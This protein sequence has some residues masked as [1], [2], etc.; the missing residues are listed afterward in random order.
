MKRLIYLLPVAA[1]FAFSACSKPDDNASTGDAYITV[2]PSSIQDVPYTGDTYKV[3]IDANCKWTI[4][5]TDDEGNPVQWLKTDKLTGEGKATISILVEE[6]PGNVAR[7]GAVNITSDK[8]SASIDITQAAN[9]GGEDPGDDGPQENPGDEPIV[10]TFDFSGAPLAG[11]P[12]EAGTEAVSCV[13][14]LDGTDYTF[15]LTA[16]GQATNRFPYWKEGTGIVITKYRYIGLPAIE[17]YRLTK[18]VATN[19]KVAEEESKYGK[20]GVANQ[21]ENTA[22][23]PDDE[24]GHG[25]VKGGDPQVWSKLVDYTYELGGTTMNTVYY[26][27][28][29]QT[30]GTF[31]KAVTLTFEKGDAPADDPGDD[32]GDNPGGDPGDNPG[33]DPSDMVLDFDFSEDPLEGW[34][35][36]STLPEHVDGGYSYIYPIDGENYRIILA[37]CDGAARS[38]I[39]WD[40]KPYGLRVNIYR[41]VGLPAIE[42]YKL[43][44]V[45]ATCGRR[46]SNDAKMCIAKQI[47]A[48]QVHPTDEAGHG[49]VTGG[50]PQDWKAADEEYTYNLKDTEANKVYYLS[51]VTGTTS[52]FAWIRHIKATY[53]H[54]T[55]E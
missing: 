28:S 48:N 50:D 36:S 12:T 38:A 13:Y 45:V 26:L 51:N 43:K 1:L 2:S 25:Y 53:S 37:D 29:L 8:A 44:T 10:L 7:S 18:L 5:K 16:D 22:K 3:E 24:G 55:P 9:P 31:L 33:G 6:N 46:R 4:T 40:E 35:T 19:A 23:A 11:W 32:P 17:G 34:P 47:E 20:A 21:V 15:V 52:V 30:Y 49:V 27:V 42:G 39:F 41:Y 14:P 54:V